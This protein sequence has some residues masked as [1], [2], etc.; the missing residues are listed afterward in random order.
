MINYD[1]RYRK[2]RGLMIHDLPTGDYDCWIVGVGQVTVRIEH[3]V[4]MTVE[5]AKDENGVFNLTEYD[6]DGVTLGEREEYDA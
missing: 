5:T 6:C 3:G 1:L 4:G 2:E